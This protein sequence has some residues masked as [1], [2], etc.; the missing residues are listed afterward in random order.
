MKPKPG[1]FFLLADDNVS[2]KDE[3]LELSPGKDITINV[4]PE[5]K[6]YCV[7]FSTPKG[8]RISCPT[9]EILDKKNFHCASCSMSEFFTCKAIC[10]GDFCHPSSDEAKE[11]CWVTKAYVY[12][13]SIA[14]KIKVGSSTSV[15]RRWL[16]QGSDAGVVIAEGTGLE[17]RALEHLIGSFPEFPLAMRI[18]QKMK[19][20]GQPL[21]KEKITQEIEQAIEKIYSTVTSK[22]LYPKEQLSGVVFLDEFQGSINKI[23]ARPMFKTMDDTGLDF[24]GKIVGVKGSILVVQ[25]GS[26]YY[27]TNLNDLIGSF[28][29]IKDEVKEMK[30]Q[31]SLFD[32][33]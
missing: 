11:Y 17:P 18:N 22:I 20:M 2:M 19:T 13:T 10:Q 25:N 4:E 26:T 32:F 28:I 16:G 12:L 1:P 3:V 15:I 14:G 8:N 24:S 29:E 5:S 9:A 7:G 21:D 33:V 6:K 27:A 23:K 30:G 31:K